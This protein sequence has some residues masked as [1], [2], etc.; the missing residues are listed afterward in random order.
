MVVHGHRVRQ[1]GLP[2][3]PHCCNNQEH[4]NNCAKAQ[5]QLRRKT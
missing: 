2:A 3:D 1:L 4:K 5:C